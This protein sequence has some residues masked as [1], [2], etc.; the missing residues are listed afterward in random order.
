MKKAFLVIAIFLCV[1]NVKA[2]QVSI[3]DSAVVSLLTC[4]PGEEVYSKFGHTAIRIADKKNNIDVVF[5]YGIFSFETSNFYYK[6]IKGETD[7]QLGIYDT[8]N[9]LPEYAQR[10]SMVVEQVLN[11]SA[12]EK[13]DLFNL[14]M[15]NYLPEN[16]TYR[17]NFIFDNCATRPRDKILASLHGYVKF[18]E[19]YE[20]KTFRQLVGSYVGNDTWLKFGIDLVFGIRAD[21]IASESESMFL[22]EVLMGEFQTAQITAREGGTKKLISERRILVQKI[23]T[24][25]ESTFWLFKPMAF[26]II[27]L[28]I[29][30]A[31]TFW[32]TK[33]RY[34]YRPFDAFLFGLTGVAGVIIA[35]LMFFSL[36]PLVKSNL[37]LLWLNPLS[38]IIV[39]LLWVRRLRVA[40]FFYQ[41]INV[42][43]LLA[44]LFTFAISV[45]SINIAAYPIIVL[46]LMRSVSWI[47]L[48]RKKIYRRRR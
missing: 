14:L 11:L 17:Y 34:Y 42:V 31:I 33:R 7:Y 45:Q 39:S 37:N 10:N 9:F 19:N 44:A 12:A 25:E 4:S 32:D 24:K 8:R 2:Q 1:M 5:N 18:Q 20:S 21:R 3:S 28:I 22:P 30:S 6:F 27:L 16:R 15:Q 41:I 29:G 26:S 40:L 35:Y 23:D 36:H 48:S 47:S 13:R 38:L 46:L 43:F